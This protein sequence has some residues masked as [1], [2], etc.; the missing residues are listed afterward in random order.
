MT[1]VSSLYPREAGLYVQR[2]GG[3]EVRL[4]FQRVISTLLAARSDS[5]HADR[6]MHP[7]K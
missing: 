5:G 1:A 3:W 4:S 6:R 2:R 7:S